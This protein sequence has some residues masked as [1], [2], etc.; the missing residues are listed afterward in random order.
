MIAA[1]AELASNARAL[2][3]AIKADKALWA[4]VCKTATAN[5]LTNGKAIESLMP[6]SRKSAPKKAEQPTL[7]GSRKSQ[8][9][10]TIR[11]DSTDPADAAITRKAIQQL[12]VG[13]LVSRYGCSQ[14]GANLAYREMHQGERERLTLAAKA[15]KRPNAKASE[16]TLASLE[17]EIKL[18][19]GK[20]DDAEREIRKAESRKSEAI[21]Q[22]TATT[23]KSG[24]ATEQPTAT[25]KS[26]SKTQPTKATAQPKAEK[27]RPVPAFRDLWASAKRPNRYLSTIVEVI[28]GNDALLSAVLAYSENKAISLEDAVTNLATMAGVTPTKVR[29]PRKAAKAAEATAA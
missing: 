20:R 18:A 8:P 12:V 5:C 26:S 3:A 14:E 25:R 29:K 10:K 4:F 19:K 13:Y 17:A 7:K 22:R 27:F 1:N 6:K 21:K 11:K 15:A 9:T 24:K 16:P 23:H 2:K 28:S